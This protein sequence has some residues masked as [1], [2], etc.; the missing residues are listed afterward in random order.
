MTQT[1]TAALS[2]AP[3][4]TTRAGQMVIRMLEAAGGRGA[5]IKRARGYEEDL[6]GGVDIWAAMA[7]RYGLQLEVFSGSRAKIPCSGPLVLVANHP[8]GILDGLMLGHLLQQARGDFKILANDVFDQA[9]ALGEAILPVSFEKSQEALAVNLETRRRAIAYLRAGGAIG[10]FPGGTVST[11]ARAF[12][13]A[14][15][16]RWRSFTAKMIVRSGAAVVPVYFA[17]QNSRWFQLASHLHSSLRLGLLIGEFQRQVDGPVKC[18]IGAP[19]GPA[20]L[21]PFQKDPR[22]MMDFLRNTT[23]E[24]SQSALDH[25]VYG[26]EIE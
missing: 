7:A 26:P 5:L 16:P 19:I 4:A 24:L 25:A 22:A 17:G 12:G 9:S 11:A 15:D 3:S 1:S 23:Y 20:D 6:A 2:Y 13:P 8:F 18:A 21:Q 14:L 10:V